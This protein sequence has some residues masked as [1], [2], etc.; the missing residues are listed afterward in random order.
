M[1]GDGLYSPNEVVCLICKTHYKHGHGTSNLHDHLRRVHPTKLDAD[2]HKLELEKDLDRE[3]N[4]DQ[5]SSSKA[6][7]YGK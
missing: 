4:N 1:I 6:G 5:T 2:I 7:N 3:K